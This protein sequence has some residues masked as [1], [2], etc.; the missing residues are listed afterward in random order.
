MKLKKLII[1]LAILS[2][3]CVNTGFAQQTSDYAIK[4]I[5]NQYKAQNYLGCINSSDNIIKNE[6]PNNC[7]CASVSF[8][9][10]FLLIASTIISNNLPPSSPG[11]GSKLVTPSEI[12]ISAIR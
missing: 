7:I 2:F 12:E 1:G 10:G 5:I 8:F 9:S 3:C 4:G 6:N 11:I